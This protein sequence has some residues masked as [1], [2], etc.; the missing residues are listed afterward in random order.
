MKTPLSL[1]LLAVAAGAVQA[2]PVLHFNLNEA[3][4]QVVDSANAYLA[5][6]VVFESG[7]HYGQASVT[8]GSH[9]AITI[10]PAQAAA[11]GTSIDFGTDDNNKG[12]LQLA[13]S[14]R[15]A[16]R[17]LLAPGNSPSLV[18]G[19]LTVM[20][21][22][23]LDDIQSPFQS[24]LTSSSVGGANNIL[25]GG[26]RLGVALG[27]A[28]YT[29]FGR[30]AFTQPTN[31]VAG[32]WYQLA[33]TVKNDTVSFYVNGT[34]VGSNGLTLRFSDE[35]LNSNVLIGGSAEN[36]DANMLGR[37]D[38]VK[39]FATALDASAIAAEALPTAAVPEPATAA[40]L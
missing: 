6:P 30:E 13:A 11:F 24:I 3:S 36:G 37:L 40:L 26:W 19:E 15:Q 18:A 29:H 9:G 39:V 8:A 21:W 7:M 25:R 33:S 34:L 17:D 12:Y 35:F 4:G 10:T 31:L 27:D 28:R 38:E 20:A 2:Q 14:G 23:K 16:V 22:I 32:N 5:D 1:A